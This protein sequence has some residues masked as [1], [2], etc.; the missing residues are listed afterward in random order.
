[1]NKKLIISFF[2]I[3]FASTNIYAIKP[4][5]SGYLPVDGGK[6]YYQ[7][8]GNKHGKPIIVLHGGPGLDSSYLLPQM[9]KIANNNNLVTFYDQRGSGKSLGF[10]L[11]ESSINIQNFVKDLDRVRN[12]L[13][14][15]KVIII[16]HS[17]GALLGMNYAI[18][19]PDNVESLILVSGAPSNSKGFELFFKKYTDRTK[20]IQPEL[21]KIEESKDYIAGEPKAVERYFRKIFSVYFYK[22]EEVSE[23]TLQFTKESALSGRKVAEIFGSTYL[24]DYKLNLQ[25]IKIPVLVIHGIDDIVP[26]NTAILTHNTIMG[27]KM[28]TLQ[29]CDHFPYIEKQKEFLQAIEQFIGNYKG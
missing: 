20:L 26:I 22:P 5:S 2:L 14:H 4:S 23:L 11:D 9:A 21:T 3:F 6:L 15:D 27:S 16:G 13:G 25:K 24:A 1:M 19:Y 18:S 28:I 10:E 7:Q 8:F 29:E 12:S 17:W